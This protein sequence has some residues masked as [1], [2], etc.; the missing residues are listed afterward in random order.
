MH[1][2]NDNLISNLNYSY[3]LN[4]ESA[5]IITLSENPLSK[6]LSDRCA[7]SCLRV[8]MPFKIW[9]GFDGT[10]GELIV[11][12]H[13]KNKE[14]LTW[15]KLMNNTLTLTSIGCLFSHVSLWA[16]CLE[17][18]RPI[19]ILEHDAIMVK[20]YLQHSCW[21]A[22]TYLGSK[23]QFDNEFP[24]AYQAPL[25]LLNSINYR[26]ILRT[27]SYS[28]DPAIAKNLISHIL[29]FGICAN[30]DETIR[31]DIFPICQNGLYSYNADDGTT[32]E[33]K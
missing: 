29:K 32:I 24:L 1:N 30:A 13:L 19:V 22:I 27:H 20:P 9:E 3:N 4:I 31:A 25:Y 12:E 5:Y 14:W 33:K 10:T 15:I 2:C 11:P 18:D 28:I 26:H 23:E 7:E 16:H 17:I 8:N 6:K 21:N